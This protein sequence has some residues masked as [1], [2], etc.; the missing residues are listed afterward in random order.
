MK[1]DERNTKTLYHY[2]VSRTTG[3]VISIAFLRRTALLPR[4]VAYLAVLRHHSRARIGKAGFQHHPPRIRRLDP[5]SILVGPADETALAATK[6][7]IS[8]YIWV[9][10][11]DALWRE[12]QPQLALLADGRVHAPFVQPHAMRELHVEDPDGF[13]IFFGETA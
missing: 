5:G 10:D 6:N 12:L 13:L 8:A 7:T 2:K 3:S 11:L 1:N 9:A 4:Q